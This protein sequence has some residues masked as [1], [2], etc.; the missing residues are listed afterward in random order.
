MKELFNLA[1]KEWEDYTCISF[2]RKDSPE[3]LTFLK[4]RTDHEGCYSFVGR[5]AKGIL[6]F[7]SNDNDANDLTVIF[8]QSFNNIVHPCQT[9]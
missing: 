3:R 8:M 7:D 4:Y 6:Y 1:M 5:Q 9:S 2:A